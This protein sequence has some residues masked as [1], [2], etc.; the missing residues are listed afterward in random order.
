[1]Y[2]KSKQLGYIPAYLADQITDYLEIIKNA[3]ITYSLLLSKRDANDKSPL[4]DI[5]IN[6]E[7]TELLSQI[8]VK[9]NSP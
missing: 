7:D 6:L 2:N 3:V 4:M 9:F 8:C 5:E 1:M